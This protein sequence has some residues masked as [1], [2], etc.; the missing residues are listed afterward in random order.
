MS[1]TRDHIIIHSLRDTV[2]VGDPAVPPKPSRV[3]IWHV[4]AAL[5]AV[6]FALGAWLA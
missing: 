3:R 4:G 6:G 2:S 1:H 5:L